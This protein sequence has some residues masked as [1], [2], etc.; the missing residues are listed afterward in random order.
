MRSPILNLA[1]VLM[2]GGWLCSSAN[3]LDIGEHEEVGKF[4]DTMVERH[5]FSKR[6]L[7]RLFKQVEIKQEV[8]D[9]INRPREAS[10][11]HAYRKIFITDYSIQ[12]GKKYWLKHKEILSRVA[13]EQGVDPAIIVAILGVETQYGRNTGGFRVIDALTTLTLNYPRRSKFFRNELEEFLLLTRELEK[14]PLEIVGSYAG[15]IGIPQFIPSSYRQYAVDYDK[16]NKRDLISSHEDTIASIANFFK[17]HGWIPNQ[18]VIDD[19]EF[20]DTQFV[21]LDKLGTNTKHS[22]K[23]F[24]EYGVFPPEVVDGELMAALIELESEQGPEYRL[25]Y[26]NFYVITRY[27]RSTN[28]AMAVYD[29]SQSIRRLIE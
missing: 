17:L 16:D 21:W 28:Y 3:A 14:N 7:R 25:A 23:H 22:L 6:K 15:A 2:L 10:P 27:N 20:R 11:W 12:R 8:I 19:V 5:G 24:L 29:L 1:V 4:I 9:A 13:E 18:P 26:N